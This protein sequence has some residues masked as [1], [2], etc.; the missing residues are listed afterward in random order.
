[1]TPVKRLALA[2]AI[3]LKA[4]DF[5]N[6]CK[7]ILTKRPAEKQNSPQYK[8]FPNINHNILT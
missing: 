8:L 5:N 4:H 3:V 6:A 7:F 2:G 1:M